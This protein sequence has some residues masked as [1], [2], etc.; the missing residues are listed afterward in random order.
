[1]DLDICNDTGSTLHTIHQSTW[2]RFMKTKYT[3]ESTIV[4]ITTL[5]GSF[6]ALSYDIQLRKYGDMERTK[7]LTKWFDIE[8]IIQPDNHKQLSGSELRNE[9]IFATTMG[10]EKP[11]AG[12]SKLG[13]AWRLLTS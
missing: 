6:D 12:T 3:G 7:P 11:I 1:M 4:P 9:C 5:G 8:T 2:N 13:V 10:N